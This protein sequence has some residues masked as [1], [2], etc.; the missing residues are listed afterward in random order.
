[1]AYEKTVWV[2]GQAPA[3]DADHL[4]KI[5]QGI[6]D[7]V[8]ITPQTLSAEQQAQVRTNIDAAPGGF[9]LGLVSTPL[10]DSDDM[11]KWHGN[12]HFDWGSIVPKNVPTLLR[13]NGMYQYMF[14]FGTD[15][16]FTQIVGCYLETNPGLIY[17]QTFAKSGGGLILG[18]WKWLIR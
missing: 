8:S 15:S 9:G 3:L 6:A 10:N 1:M 18:E 4:N 12:G 5:E 13:S 14:E 11:N 17:R 16:G 7:A 2:N